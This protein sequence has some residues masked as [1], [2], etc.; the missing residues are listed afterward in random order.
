MQRRFIDFFDNCAA[1][2]LAVSGREIVAV[3]AGPVPRNV[4]QEGGNSIGL[5]DVDDLRRFG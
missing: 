4:F 5:F 1:V 2:I 3:E